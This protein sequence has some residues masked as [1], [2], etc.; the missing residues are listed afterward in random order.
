VTRART[1]IDAA[2]AG[3]GII[4]LATALELTRRGMQ[5]AV[6]ERG[7]AMSESSWAAA[8]MLAGCDPENPAA[9]RELSALSLR[10]YP[11]FL[12]QI[13]RLSGVEV[14]LRTRQ[15][16]QGTPHPLPAGISA[17]NAAEIQG[18]APG[19]DPDG[20][21]F[22]LL[23]EPSL[24]PRDLVRALPRAVRAAGVDLQEHVSVNSVR[25]GG[26]GIEV[27]TSAG[28]FSARHFLNA[29]GA[30]AA[31]LTRDLP[32]AP[33]KGQ[34]L[35]VE[36]T[37]EMQL[38]RVIRTPELYIVPRGGNRYVIGATVEDVGFDKAVNRAQVDSLFAAAGALWTPLRQGRI[39]ETWAGLRPGSAD[40]LPVI[41]SVAPG[42][43][44]AAGHFRNGILLAPGTARVLGGWMTGAAPE[45][46]L[47]PFRSSRFAAVS[48]HD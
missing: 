14:S 11:E 29:T 21:T 39:V 38:F 48:V 13:G 41:D 44:V 8:G 12:A 4:G 22:F 34:M 35:A 25:S 23:D 16:L 3:G 42:V 6:F 24:D 32:V 40:D 43:L 17:L 36:L 27:E 45:I 10:L 28:R 30:W 46:D 31:S 9:L 7:D 20:L 33:R 37:G 26:D 1:E 19:L 15:T 18:F 2:I 5:V 47:S